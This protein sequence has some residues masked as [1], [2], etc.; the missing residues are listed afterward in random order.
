MNTVRAFIAIELPDNIQQYLTSLQSK[1]AHSNEHTIKWVESHNI[2]L[3]LKFLGDITETTIPALSRAIRNSVQNISAF[4]LVTDIP[5]SFP[6]NKNPR[7]I[8]IGLSGDIDTLVH[9]QKSIELN[10][11]PLGFFADSKGF[12]P[13]LTLGRLRDN[14]SFQQRQNIGKT[15]SSLKLEEKLPFTVNNIF[16]VKSTLT[17]H[18][19]IYSHLDIIKLSDS[20]PK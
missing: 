5:G 19:P 6:N 15:L 8:W 4:T 7:I 17:S 14:I 12:S 11:Q 18:S 3:T 9:L 20:L 16:L 13:H 2:H 10:I 1:I